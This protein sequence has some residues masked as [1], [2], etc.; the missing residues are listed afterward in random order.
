MNEYNP[1]S[2]N[3]SY[4]IEKKNHVTIMDLHE[5]GGHE[6]YYFGLVIQKKILVSIYFLK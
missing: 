3:K 1:D 6:I 5:S 4:A 2:V